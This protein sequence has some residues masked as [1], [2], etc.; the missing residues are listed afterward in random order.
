M[1]VN[2][3]ADIHSHGVSVA[4]SKEKRDAK[5]LNFV[6]LHPFWH[7]YNQAVLVTC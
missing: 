3:P 1:E 5:E 2:L 7:P 4:C 6:T